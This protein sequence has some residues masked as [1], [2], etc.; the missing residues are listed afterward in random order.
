MEILVV[1]LARGCRHP[2]VQSRPAASSASGGRA[3]PRCD[4]GRGGRDPA[5]RGRRRARH[6]RPGATSTRRPGQDYRRALD[7]YE[8]AKAELRRG[9][10]PE[11]V[12]ESPGPSRTAA[13]RWPACAPGWRASRCRPAG[14]RAS[15]TRST[16]RRPT[17]SSGRRR[18]GITRPVPACA[19][20]AERVRAGAEPDTRRC[21]VGSGPRAVL[22][23]R[24]GYGPWAGVLRRYAR[25]R[26]AARRAARRRA[27]SAASAAGTATARVRHVGGRRRQRGERPRRW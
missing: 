2:L 10:A 16:A 1:L 11:D 12:G 25:L 27:R 8:E 18:A 21:S 15:S 3:L 22:G 17:T 13:T 7:S 5:R 23:R 4:S 24:T 9:A 26:A 20:D 19:A 6:R 14:R